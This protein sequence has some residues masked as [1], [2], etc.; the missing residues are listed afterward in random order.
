MGRRLRSGLLIAAGGVL[1]AA[2]AIIYSEALGAT[3]LVVVYE[4]HL[5]FRAPWSE[6]PLQTPLSAENLA[7]E[8]RG[9][10][11][12]AL[13]VASLA[14]LVAL[15]RWRRVVFA[16]FS[17]RPRGWQGF[18]SLFLGFSALAAFLPLS[19]GGALLSLYFVLGVA[20]FC[21]L[22]FG[23]LGYWGG[24]QER[25][26]RLVGLPLEGLDALA[27]QS[28]RVLMVAMALLVLAEALLISLLVFH[29]V[30]HVVD[31][32]SYL[33]QARIFA[34]GHLYIPSHPLPEFFRLDTVVSN[35][36]WFSQYPPGHAILLLMGVMVDAPWLV[37]PLLGAL[38]VPSLFLLGREVYGRPTALLAALLA[39]L[40]PFLV[41]MSGEFY[42]H[43]SAFLFLTL[44]LLHYFRLSSSGGARNALLA[45][46]FLGLALWSRPLTALA[47]ATPCAVDALVSLRSRR[48]G[49]VRG[50][51]LLSAVTVT[52]AGILLL[53]NHETTGAYLAF[54][55]GLADGPGFGWGDGLSFTRALDRIQRLNDALLGWS[56]PTLIPALFAFLG[57]RPTRPDYLLAGIFLSLVAF[58][59]PAAYSDQEF[60]PRYLY[61]ASGA[62]FL[63]SAR[64]LWRM[65]E[66]L[67]RL[68]GR[69]FQVQAVRRLAAFSVLLAFFLCV[70]MGWTPRAR[71]YGSAEWQ[72]ARHD[73]AYLAAKAANVANAIV[74][75]RLPD[76]PYGDRWWESVFLYNGLS[77]D[78]TDIIFARDLGERNLELMRLYPGR[79]YFLADSSRL[80]PL[81]P[82]AGPLTLGHPRSHPTDLSTL[83]SASPAKGIERSVQ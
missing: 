25:G 18:A 33:F 65:H 40:S 35:E 74:F 10:A 37:N 52:F 64:G 31:G 46:L 62:L 24:G 67:E 12:W 79:Q 3:D 58:H 26:T 51:A 54:G 42:S 15:A 29:G 76:S 75:V 14:G 41:F 28:D 20:G 55:Y 77:L 59:L 68:F 2:A 60:G 23:L 17:R 56:V 50:L 36:R 70:P 6:R 61:E 11:L 27:G 81:E 72:W 22:V 78:T 21:L 45:G 19:G 7:A 39:C 44:F 71:F 82:G 32:I 49:R 13:V 69:P 57:G 9:L 73:E 1:L 83:P 63:L 34:S 5:S 80:I 53:Y 47:V 48:S 4:G 66:G 8:A 30:P 16:A 43:A 38:T